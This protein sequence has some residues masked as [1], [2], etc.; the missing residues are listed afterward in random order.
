MRCGEDSDPTRF[1]EGIWSFL[2]GDPVL[3]NV[4]A[5]AVEQAAADPLAAP[6]G[7]RWLRVHDEDRLVGAAMWTPP[8]GVWLSPM[9][10]AA[11]EALADFLVAGADRPPSVDGQLEA[12]TA[13]ARRY[14]AVT[15]RTVT[16]GA[17]QRLF[18]LDRV[19][20]PDGVPG[21]ARP[22]RTADRQLILD[23]LTRFRE[24]VSPRRPPVDDGPQVDRRLAA[25]PLMWFW[26][27]DREPVSFAWRTPVAPGPGRRTTVCRISS[28]YTPP[29]HRGHGYASA[30]VAALSQDALDD[31]AEACMLYT[32]RANPISNKIYQAIGY[33]PVGGGQEW[34]FG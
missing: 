34:R 2:S 16:P 30:N 21:R 1:A 17:A 9:P 22:A 10:A 7:A 23:W 4:I 3:T 15:G 20:A 14:A 26:E 12:A 27:V 29:Q 31:G 19:I 33:R 11:A 13:F 28:V 25:G 18:R 5:T 8:R 6:P 24:D 32:D